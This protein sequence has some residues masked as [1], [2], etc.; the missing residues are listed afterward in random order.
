MS[1]AQNEPSCDWSYSFTASNA[2]IAI[3]QENFNNM[4]IGCGTSS[5]EIWTSIS[6]I[7]CPVWLGV[8]YTDN[9]GDLKCGGYVE[10]DNTQTFSITAWGDD[11]T[12]TE[13]DGFSDQEPYTFKL[14]LNSEES[15]PLEGWEAQMSTGGPFN[16][17]TYTTNGL[18][19]LAS[20]SY[21]SSY[22]CSDIVA[23]CDIDLN[24]YA[25]PK[26]ILKTV[27]LYGRNISSTK[28]AG[29]VIQI[30]SD[31]TVSKTYRF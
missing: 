7:A 11:P 16:S 15:Y 14:C 12:T 26:K 9:N 17:E 5:G 13:K 8:F 6:T 29:F 10:W 30:F 23:S 19:G 24:E 31:Q 1:F 20:L 28:N 27:D 2:T 25:E 21:E 3:Q 4:E 22:L 18:S